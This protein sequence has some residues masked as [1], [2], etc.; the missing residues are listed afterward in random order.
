MG[1]TNS[2]EGSIYISPGAIASI[3]SH[4]VLQT[5][6]V[7]GMASRNALGQLAAVL[8]R[9]PNHGVTVSYRESDLSIDIYVIVQHG[10]NISSIAESMIDSVRY[11]VEKAAGIPVKQVNV[12][13][14]GLR[15]P[16]A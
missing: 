8:T 4:A 5:Y 11:N 10:T 14:Q 3:A 12:Y 13:V 16:E 2:F 9:D 1:E 6:G 7:V 15:Q